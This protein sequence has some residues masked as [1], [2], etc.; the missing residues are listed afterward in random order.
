M[1]AKGYTRAATNMWWV[2][3][4]KDIEKLN[5]Q[6]ETLVRAKSASKAEA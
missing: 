5:T 4:T 2:T 1:T 6:I 3:Y